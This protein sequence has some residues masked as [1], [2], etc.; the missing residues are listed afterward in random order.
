M[1]V[2]DEPSTAMWSSFDEFVELR[3]RS[4]WQQA[5]LLTHDAARAEDLVQTALAKCYARFDKLNRDGSSFEAYVRRALYTSYLGWRGRRWS[6]EVPSDLNEHQPVDEG[7]EW[8]SGIDLA[9]ALRELPRAQRAVIV[10]RY[11]EDCSEADVAQT[12][13]ISV[14]TVKSHAHRGLTAL[15]ASRHLS[16]EES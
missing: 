7:I 9:R 15:R 10:L 1:T 5:W 4:L 6:G 12:L 3:Q 2:M 13:G 16:E 11:V 14:G 8:G